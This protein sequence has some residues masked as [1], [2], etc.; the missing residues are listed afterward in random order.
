MQ[1]PQGALARVG[2]MPQS[3]AI[4]PDGSMLA[5]VESG[6]DPAKLRILSVPSLA[7]RGV[8]ELPDAFGRPVWDGN[9]T[10]HLAGGNSDAI[11]SVDIENLTAAGITKRALA[12]GSWPAAVAV[13]NAAGVQSF[14]AAD[15]GDGTVNLEGK[16]IAVGAHPFDVLYSPDG[17]LLY[18]SVRQ[19][20]TVAV[21]DVKTKAVVTH[22]PVGNHPGA[23]ALSSDGNTLYVAE[24]DDDSIGIV[25]TAARKRLRGI[26]VGLH[27]ARVH[28]NGASPNAIVLRGGDLWISLGAQ[29]SIARIRA[30]RV[31]ERIP[32][33]WYPTGIAF[34]TGGTLF[35]ANGRG[36]SAPPNPRFDPR[37]RPSP[38][39][40]GSLNTGSV[41]AVP[42]STYAQLANETNLVLAAAQPQWAAPPP[43]QTIVRSNGPVKHVIYI[44]K[45][46]RTYDQVLG[47]LGGADGDAGLAVFGARV[48]PNQH[49]ISRRFGTFDNAYAD[50]EV[51]APG[52]NWTDAAIAND[53]VER[54]WPPNYGGRRDLYDAQD[55][56]APDVPHNGYL[57]DAAQRAHVSFRDYGEDIDFPA[58][59]PKIAVNTFAGLAGHFDP[60]YVGWDLRTSDNVRFDEWNREFQR[61]AANGTLPQLEIVY[62][63]NDHTAGTSPGMSTP[64]AYVATND[65][66]V[67][68]LVQAVSRSRYWKSTAILVLED[69]AQNGPDHVSDQRSTF[70]IASP[71]AKGGLQHAHYSTASFVHTIEL[72]LGLPQLSVY[73]TTA[74]PLY[75]AFTVQP[76]NAAQFTALKPPAEMMSAVNQK[77]AYGAQIS[78]RLDFSRPDA[79]NEEQLNDILAHGAP[80]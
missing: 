72:F 70:Y 54:F 37:K 3:I 40:I 65:Y 76:L 47:D 41:R 39:Y 13:R 35:I 57:W 27:A 42:A 6:V 58:R 5:V 9:R 7:Q 12:K 38:W 22:I 11:L 75:D 24:S 16:S 56:A 2:T 69:D 23:L 64:Q 53:Y 74:R 32:A 50:A 25:D 63:P 45:E 60:R 18:V 68:R 4:S 26:D 77:T 71:Y 8:L 43:Q 28:G 80:R 10:V 66:A 44:I 21:I 34:A 61:F 52:H 33:G 62:F 67:G 14:A 55:G 17:S 51:S 49:V 78:A 19:T 36:E 73:D 31:I 1:P 15:D 59:G 46:N 30:G 29:N 48:T 79:A 20:N